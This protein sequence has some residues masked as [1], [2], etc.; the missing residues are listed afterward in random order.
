[1]GGLCWVLGGAKGFVRFF[2]LGWGLV[3]GGVR[4]YP[5]F[6][7][8]GERCFLGGGLVVGRGCWGGARVVCFGGV[9]GG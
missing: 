2:V 1:V 7:R 9:C 8:G 3:G 5:W 6:G 4:V